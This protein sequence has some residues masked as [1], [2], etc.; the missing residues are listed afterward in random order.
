LS[1][2]GVVLDA[3]VLIPATLR[4]TLLRAAEKGMY[5]LHWSDEILD[6]VR[7]NLIKRA[8]TS[9]ADAQ[10][11]IDQ[12]ASFFA[13]ANVRGFE[14]LIPAMTNDQKDRHVLAAAVMSRSQV[15]VTSNIKDFQK[16]ALDPF[17]IEAQTPDEFLTHLFYLDSTVIT[18]IL[19]EQAN[20]LDNPPMSVPDVLDVLSLVAPGFVKLMQSTFPDKLAEHLIVAKQILDKIAARWPIAEQVRGGVDAKLIPAVATL[21]VP[22]AEWNALTKNEQISLTYY[23]E[24][25]IGDIR[26]NPIK[27]MTTPTTSPIYSIMLEN[28]RSINEGFWEILI[29]RINDERGEGVMNLMFDRSLVQGDAWWDFDQEKLGIRAS[30]FR[31]TDN[32]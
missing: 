2:F 21:I 9:P 22:Q 32:T 1:S 15:I 20:D 8:M 16:K 10:D 12:M 5:R 18:E 7:R 13:E 28:Y 23:A 31:Q 11:L 17:G 14:V 30:T 27:Y 4:D 6:E 19:S 25:M 29:G 26:S 3:C 24:S